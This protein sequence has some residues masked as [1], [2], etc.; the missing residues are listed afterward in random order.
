MTLLALVDFGRQ[1]LG[2][3][4]LTPLLPKWKRMLVLLDLVGW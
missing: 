1:F 2:S 3:G 4:W